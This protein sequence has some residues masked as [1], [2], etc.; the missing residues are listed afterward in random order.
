MAAAIPPVSTPT[1]RRPRSVLILTASVGA[2]HN[3][4]A[5]AIQAQLAVCQP[6]LDVV[7]EDVLD[8]VPLLFRLKYQ[9]GYELTVTQFPTCYGIGYALTDRPNGPGRTLGERRRLWNERRALEPLRQ[10]LVEN[11]P[12]LI[13]H[14][15]FLAPPAIGHW[16]RT[17]QTPWRQMAVVTDVMP[18]RWWLA[19]HVDRWFLP[20]GVGQPRLISWGIAPEAITVTGMPI[21]PKWTAPLP[22]EAALRETWSLPADKSIVLLSGGTNF[23]CG[24]VAR[25]ARRIVRANPNAC[26]VVLGGRNK[27]LLAQ[28]GQLR[29]AHEKRIVPISFT[30]RVHELVQ[31]A[32]LMITKPGG[33]TTAECLAKGTPMVFLSPVAGQESRNARFFQEQGA[34]LTARTARQVVATATKLLANPAQ[35]AAMARAAKS[36]YRPGGETIAQHITA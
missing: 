7:I 2:G 3:Q 16:N 18:H 8:Y 26:V 24:P 1:P 35:L 33:M 25:I 19:E 6:D 23:V 14:T 15:H 20:H 34:G 11:P 31:L 17:A 29:E 32:S 22:E 30:D 27:K 10:R 36:L 9:R 13:V 5:R 12:D 28:L 4:A 21:E